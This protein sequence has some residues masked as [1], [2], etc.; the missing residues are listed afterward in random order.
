MRID[1]V[2][3]RRAANVSPSP[4]I[5]SWTS[6][7]ARLGRRVLVFP[8]LE[9]TNSF[10]LSLGGAPDNDGVVVLAREQSA[11]RGQHG[12]SWQAPPGSSVLMSVLLF[13]PAQV[14][15]PSLL[16]AWAAVSV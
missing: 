12:R 3:R 1:G 10:A 4:S 8:R 6:A 16:T 14:C 13:P 11:G 2:G 7:P 5:Q 15:R 9:S